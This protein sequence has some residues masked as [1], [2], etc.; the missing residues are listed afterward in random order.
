MWQPQGV[1]HA[2]EGPAACQAGLTG[3]PLLIVKPLR[4]FMEEPVCING[5]ICFRVTLS[6][7]FCLQH[8]LDNVSSIA[9]FKLPC[10][11]HHFS[12]LI[13]AEQQYSKLQ[14]DHV[15]SDCQEPRHHLQICCQTQG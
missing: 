8:V 6:L 10:L 3:Q 1:S 13:A 5:I 15:G 2:S 4:L 11:A 14:G 12:N 9:P 7:S